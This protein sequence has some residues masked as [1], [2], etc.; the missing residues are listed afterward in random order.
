PPS[1]PSWSRSRS[2]SSWPRVRGAPKPPRRRRPRSR[3]SSSGARTR[4]GTGSWRAS[5]GPAGTGP[6][7]AQVRGPRSP[8]RGWGRFREAWPRISRVAVLYSSEQV[9]KLALSVQR[10]VAPKVGITLL[11]YDAR[12]LAELP[13]ALA[14]ITRERAD[15]LFVFD[16][17]I[18]TTHFSLISEFAT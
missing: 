5:P 16:T 3:S 8:G 15:G 13:A 6:G 1:R 18:N 10:R 7:G 4:S 14:A 2:R 9:S 12:T 17:Q 11:P